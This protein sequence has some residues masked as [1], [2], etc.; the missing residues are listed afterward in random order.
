[1]KIADNDQG[2]VNVLVE[3][4]KCGGWADR[5]A[6]VV[7]E[8]VLSLPEFPPQV[9]GE[10]GRTG[11]ET[12]MKMLVRQ[13]EEQ[14]SITH[15]QLQATSEQLETSHEGFMSANEEM[16]SINEEFQSANEEL[17]STN[18]ELE[19]SKEELQ[20]LNEEL[21]TVNAELQ[22]KVEELNQAT[23]DMENLLTSSEIATLFLDRRMNIK[24]YTPAVAGIFNL[25]PADIGRPFRHLAGKIDWPTLTQDAE[26]VLAGQPFAERAVTSLDRGR[27]YLKRILPYRTQQG[28]IDGIVVT[29]IDIT[30]H[31][32]A[33]EALRESE[34]RYHSLFENMMEGFAFC[35]M[36]YDDQGSPVDF[37]Y[38]D[39]NNAFVRLTGLEHVKGKKVTEVIPGIRESS[40]DLF[41]IYNRVALTGEP[42]KFEIEFK[43]LS[44]WFSISVYSMEREYFVAVF[45]DISERKRAEDALRD[46]Q[47][48]N[49]FLA[50]ILEVASQPFSVGYPDGRL[51]LFNHAF[52]QLTGYTG[53]ELRSINWN[54]TLTPSEWREIEHDKLEEL[55]RTCQPVRYE[56]EYLRK[57]G[58]RVPI[59]LLV[60]LDADLD[61]KPL[62]YYAFVNDITGR[63]RAEEEIRRRVEE[64]SANNE[65][66]TRFNSA[67]VGRE[68]RMIEL[69][70][71]INELNVQTGQPPRYQLD[72]KEG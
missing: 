17:Q 45:D 20:A 16:M 5:L 25:I 15:E 10:E 30:E 40:L 29:F 70:K 27:C 26:T 54:D 11:D 57:D 41:E 39:V 62:Y 21:V 36:L 8:P 51:G 64:L 13:L 7:L 4:L 35:K 59:E 47:R 63:K 23:S 22:G 60:H 46:S 44:A 72:F 71:E 53:D 32:K 2:S 55:H 28:D 1:M 50:H 58:S 49:E 9:S 19:T 6:I 68:L 42:E 67:S 43:P 52:E 33:E 3:P 18:E 31:K 66:L 56:K 37:V 12:S 24:G 69:K 65:E 14:L 34:K 61:G 48:Q 38:L